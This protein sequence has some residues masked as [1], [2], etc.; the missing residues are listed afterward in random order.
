MTVRWEKS[1]SI[2]NFFT[3]HAIYDFG[4][5][6]NFLPLKSLKSKRAILGKIHLERYSISETVSIGGTASANQ[7]GLGRF[8]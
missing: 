4:R 3:I 8:V 6:R 1:E 5:M 2:D 7:K